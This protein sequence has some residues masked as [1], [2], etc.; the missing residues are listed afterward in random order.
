MM[1]NSDVNVEENDDESRLVMGRQNFSVNNLI[2]RHTNAVFAITYG[3]CKMLLQI[4]IANFFQINA[5]YI[6]LI[7]ITLSYQFFF[8]KGDSVSRYVFAHA[9]K[10]I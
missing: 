6:A 3:N 5:P 1:E 10:Q 9:Q 2:A 4:T 8:E 7:E